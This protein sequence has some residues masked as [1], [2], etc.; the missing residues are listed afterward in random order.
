[1]PETVDPYGRELDE[2]GA[3]IAEGREARLGRDESLGQARVIQALYRAADDGAVV[4][5]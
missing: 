3:A 2:V 1:M 4:S 5:L